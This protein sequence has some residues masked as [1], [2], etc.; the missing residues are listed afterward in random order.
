MKL[1]GKGSRTRGQ[2]ERLKDRVATGDDSLRW[3]L[4]SDE[5][6]EPLAWGTGVEFILEPGVPPFANDAVFVATDRALIFE[7]T[8][9]PT[10]H[11]HVWRWDW[12]ED[13]QSSA[14]SDGRENL[15]LR[16]TDGSESPFGIVEVFGGFDKGRLVGWI[17]D[18]IWDIHD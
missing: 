18:K 1:L 5:A 2:A 7:Y 14:A 12:Y 3:L 11:P 4:G 17:L 16:R 13:V 8:G 15:I 9:T 10:K 6:Q